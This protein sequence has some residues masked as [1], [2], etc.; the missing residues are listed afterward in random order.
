[1]FHRLLAA[2]ANDKPTAAAA[3]SGK[4]TSAVNSPPATALKGMP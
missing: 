2:E 1:M 3:N 4:V